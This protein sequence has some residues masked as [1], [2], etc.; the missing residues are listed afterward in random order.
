MSKIVWGGMGVAVLAGAVTAGNLY[1]DKSLREHYQQN[2]NPVP[3]V[4]SNIRTTTWGL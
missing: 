3:N 1:A 4:A 2:L